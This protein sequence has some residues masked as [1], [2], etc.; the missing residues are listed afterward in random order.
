MSLTCPQ[1]A[2]EMKEVTAGATVGYSIMLDQCPR[3]GGIWCDRWELYPLTAAAANRLDPVDEEALRQPTP[4]I[5]AR[6]ACPRCRARMHRLHDPSLPQDACIERCPNCDGMWLNRGELRRFKQ[7]G[8]SERAPTSLTGTQLDQLAH[9]TCP[10]VQTTP[11]SHLADAFD[12][13]EPVPEAGEVRREILS[14]AAWLIARSALR[15]LLH[16]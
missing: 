16:V 1:C 13:L 5:P 4:L 8:T 2:E 3:C 15:L 9:E 14:G 10:S 7:R 12:T 11:I 6:L